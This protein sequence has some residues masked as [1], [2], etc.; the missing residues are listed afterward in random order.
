MGEIQRQWAR[1]GRLGL[2]ITLAGPPN[3]GKS[4]LLNALAHRS[5]AIVTD[6]AGTTRDVVEVATALSD[7][8]TGVGGSL[9]VLLADTAGVRDGSMVPPSPPVFCLAHAPTI[10]LHVMATP[11]Y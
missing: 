7:P 3:A 1:T 10:H 11:A 5:A 2:R 6:V 8:S 4:A 9:P